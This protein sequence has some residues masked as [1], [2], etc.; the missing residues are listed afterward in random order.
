MKNN[1]FLALLSFCSCYICAQQHENIPIEVRKLMIAYPNQIKGYE[2]NCILFCD[3]SKL[4]F[5]DGKN[6]SIEDLLKIPDIQDM[7]TYSYSKSKK[8][9]TSIEKYHDAGRIRNDA[10]FKKMYG[11]TAAEV[12][13]NLVEIIWCSKLLNQKLRVSSKNDVHK[14]LLAVSDELDNHPEWKDY[15]K[16]AGTFHWRNIS[17]TKQ[18]S[19]HS[20]GIT[21]DIDTKHSNYWQWDCSCKNENADLTYKNQIPIEIVEIFEKHGFIWGGKWYHY[22]TMHFEYRPELLVED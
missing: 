22:D 3:S 1:L 7:F 8:K 15:L 10:F 16:S 14:H 13:S 9:I 5:D 20:F 17:G 21:I 11:E 2:E 12:Q 19:A 18:L 4:I 6:K